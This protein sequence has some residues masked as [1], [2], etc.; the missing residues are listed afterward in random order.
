MYI[1]IYI[2]MSGRRGPPDA[3][4]KTNVVNETMNL[5]LI[6]LSLFPSLSL[7]IYIYTYV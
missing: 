6:C 2:Y 7:Y 4:D 5:V 3:V 1:Y